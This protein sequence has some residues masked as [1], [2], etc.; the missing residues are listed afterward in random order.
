MSEALDYS[1]GWPDPAT[2][3]D[4]YAGIVRYVGT[5][6]RGKN[7]T[8]AEAQAMHAA[9]VPIALV[10]EDT[11][12]WM[13]GGS[14]A[15]NAAA[16]R[17]L[18]DAAT[19]GVG[20]RCVYF[21]CDEDIT[22]AVGMA[23]VMACLDGAAVTLGRARTGVYGEA[24]V[25]DAA[26]SAGHAV[27]GWQTRAWSGGRV[28]VR[29]HLLQQIGYVDVGGVQC[30][31]ST[32][33]KPDWGQWPMEDDVTAAEVWAEKIDYPGY[34]ADVPHAKD[35]YTAAEYLSGMSVT[36]GR[37]VQGQ[38]AHTKA[39]ANLGAQQAAV[40]DVLRQLTGGAV[41]IDYDRVRAAARDGA[42]DALS[43]LHLERDDAP[44][45]P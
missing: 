5:P 8:R 21:A 18:D 11:A 34:G 10:Y 13:R 15:G 3:V 17:A 22:T 20:V 36:G 43:H 1:A 35:A 38:A 33:L 39:L 24:D 30:D 42:D 44:P 37:L 2:V 14:A 7:L 40:L 29:A 27:W 26:L 12:G 25:I 16:R 41:P 31:R 32:V 19:C 9:G 6:G 28:S 45:A 4:A 23:Q